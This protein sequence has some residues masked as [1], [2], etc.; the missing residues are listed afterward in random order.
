MGETI[1]NI[2]VDMKTKIGHALL[3]DTEF[4]LIHDEV[5]IAYLS[6]Y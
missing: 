5:D 3:V 2:F 1:C 6:M 4:S